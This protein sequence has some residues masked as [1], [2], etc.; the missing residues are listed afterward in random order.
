MEIKNIL[1]N[2]KKNENLSNVRSSSIFKKKKDENNAEFDYPFKEEK[3][4][5]IIF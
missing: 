5:C 3:L 1:N 2:E 4:D